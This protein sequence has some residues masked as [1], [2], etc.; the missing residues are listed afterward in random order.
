MLSNRKTSKII[1]MR[2][3]IDFHDAGELARRFYSTSEQPA[4]LTMLVKYYKFHNDLAR[5]FSPPLG[6]VM[7]YYQNNRR[8][9]DFKR[10]TDEI[11]EEMIR[12][13]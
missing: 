1:R 10:I 13:D 9:A 2:E 5:I 7:L 3:D 11:K 4:K 12:E 6:K 8:R